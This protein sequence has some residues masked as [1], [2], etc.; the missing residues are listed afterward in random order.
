MNV[1]LNP[2]HKNI[3]GLI[4]W[5]ILC[6]AASAIGAMANF[7]TQAVYGQMIQPSWA[8][9]G[10]L[11]GPVWTMLYTMMAVAA[12]L[13]WRQGKFK[14]NR[15]ALSWFL[16]QL[17]LNALWSWVFF[18]WMQ[19]LWSFVNIIVLWVAILMTLVL[20]WRTNRTAGLL[21]VPYWTWVSFAAILNYAMWQLNPIYLG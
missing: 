10:W 21:L 1:N 17:G 20:F 2:A 18:A 4:A 15:L 9:P 5:L 13:I 19:G 16:L 11:F 14:I 3:I 6:F 8:P 12:W 7:N